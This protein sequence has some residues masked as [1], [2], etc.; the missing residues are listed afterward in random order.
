MLAFAQREHRHAVLARALHALL[1]GPA[2][3]ERTGKIRGI[4]IQHRAATGEHGRLAAHTRHALADP[5]EI[6]RQQRE[7]VGVEAEQ[8]GLQ[9]ALG[10]FPCIRFVDAG[11][12]KERATEVPPHRHGKPWRLAHRQSIPPS[13]LIVAPEM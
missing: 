4:C 3:G 7:A 11:R 1:T 9:K 5:A 8:I 6:E 12:T 13:T 10:D 2:H